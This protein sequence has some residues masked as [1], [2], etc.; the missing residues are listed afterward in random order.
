MD[1]VVST[2]LIPTERPPLGID[3][4]RA[5]LTFDQVHITACDD[6]ELIDPVSFMTA[7][8]PLAVPFP[9]PFAFGSGAPVLPLGK[10]PGYDEAFQKTLE[11]SQIALREGSVVVRTSPPLINS[12]LVL[13]NT[14]K[15]DG[16]PPPDWVM[17]WFRPLVGDRE[18]L[19]A[20]CRGL[21]SEA[22]LRQ[23]DLSSLAPGGL[24]LTQGF[25]GA[26]SIADMNDGSLTPEIAAAVQRLAATRL[27]VVIKS[28]GLCKNTGLHPSSG[29]EGIAALIEH[30]QKASASAVSSALEGH[31]ELDLIRR[32]MR[33]ERLVFAHQSP[34]L[35]LSQLSVEE[36]LRLRTKAWGRAAQARTAFFSRI[37]RLAE[38]CP[39]DDQFD[40]AVNEAIESFTSASA[41]LADEWKKLGAKVG[42]PVLIGALTV[43]APA[44]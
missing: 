16:W 13:F 27:G 17:R 15:P 7:T 12:G 21:P 37:R 20:A 10:M 42:L 44:S 14:P 11:E 32:A 2:L 40:R 6:R 28:I 23:L 38:E 18:V 35:I 24:A 34:D 31:S 4:K 39:D 3:L 25:S 9:I 8:M 26:P 22:R 36:V 29:D 19:L 33:V 5:L 43:S 1:E 41:D 30:L